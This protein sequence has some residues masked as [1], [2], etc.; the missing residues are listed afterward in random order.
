M[1]RSPVAHHIVAF[2][3]DLAAAESSDELAR[4]LTDFEMVPQRGDSFGERLANAHADA[5]RHGMPVLQIGMDTPQIGPEVLTW[6]ARELV[7]RGD[8]LLGPADD[9]GWWALGLP[10]PQ[11][12]RTLTE[13]PM[14]TDRT[15][16][17]TRNALL[18]CGLRVRPLPRYNDVDTFTDALQ[19]AAESN[20][21]F[22]A[23]M[24][25]LHR[26]GLVLQ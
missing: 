14:S 15:G 2:T 12:A 7:L 11:A 18:R 1:S 24:H 22:A 20:G 9:G 13:V 19:A 26:S 25:Q 5:A 6:A 8:A 17:H 10:S 4:A 3:G 16:E 23:L 21:R